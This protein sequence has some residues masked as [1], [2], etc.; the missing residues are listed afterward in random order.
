MFRSTESRRVV[1]WADLQRMT[2]ET[3][4]ALPSPWEFRARV[5]K[6]GK[7]VLSC[8][9]WK[10]MGFGTI[11]QGNADGSE[12]VLIVDGLEDVEAPCP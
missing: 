2:P 6:E 9:R 3:K 5:G 11:H 1:L 7:R 10:W 4:D 8:T 12:P